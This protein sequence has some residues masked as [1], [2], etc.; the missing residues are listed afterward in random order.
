MCHGPGHPEPSHTLDHHP[1]KT[2]NEHL[3]AAHRDHKEACLHVLAPTGT[4]GNSG[5]P[6]RA[7]LGLWESLT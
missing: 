3:V 2:G 4:Q 6:E 1:L 7:P 5:W